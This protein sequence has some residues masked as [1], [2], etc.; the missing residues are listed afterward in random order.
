[1]AERE[2]AAR[3]CQADA[4]TR[5]VIEMANALVDSVRA[6]SLGTLSAQQLAIVRTRI[7]IVD[8]G[9]VPTHHEVARRLGLHPA[10]IS[11][12]WA[13]I[14]AKLAAASARDVSTS[15]A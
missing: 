14:L 5:R 3:R 13:R 9:D 2:A 1:V 15:A 6:D 7:E 4:D 11:R 10:A 8:E 12:Q